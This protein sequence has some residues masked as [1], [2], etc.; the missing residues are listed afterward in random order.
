MGFSQVR[1]PA[2]PDG[3]NKV[4]LS[5]GSV[6]EM[7]RAVGTEGLPWWFGGKESTCQCRRPRRRGLTPGYGR[8][9]GDP[10]QCSCLE[11]PMES[12]RLQSMW[13]QRVG[14]N[15]SDWARKRGNGGQDVHFQDRGGVQFSSV[16]SLSGVRLFATPWIAARQ[17]SLSITN[18]WRFLKLM[19]MESV[20]PS[21]RL[22]L[23]RPL[24]LLIGG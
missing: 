17:A 24:L 9:H 15:W 5:Q 6:H 18:S 22:I 1:S 11:K 7:A 23:C 3:L 8:G 20:M 13:S 14:H 16:Q 4:L 2:T 19:S 10:L 21:S 12:G